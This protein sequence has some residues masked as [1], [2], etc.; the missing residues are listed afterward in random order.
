MKSHQCQISYKDGIE[1]DNTQSSIEEGVNEECFI[2]LE[3][4]K[5]ARVEKIKSLKDANEYLKAELLP[6]QKSMEK[7]EYYCWEIKEDFSKLQR[8]KVPYS[9]LETNFSVDLTGVDHL[10]DLS[11][12]EICQ[13]YQQEKISND[14]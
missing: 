1:E 6:C 4:T 2:D 9:E 8:K 13:L 11:R 14:N 3:K 12:D 7:H 5:K 10:Y